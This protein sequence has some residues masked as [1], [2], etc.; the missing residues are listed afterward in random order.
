MSRRLRRLPTKHE[1]GVWRGYI[2][3]AEAVR[4]KLAD[5]LQ[6]DFG[7]SSG[8]Y[9]VLLTLSEAPGNRLRSTELAA[10]MGWEKS[11][12][13]HHLSRMERRNLVS[14]QECAD[15]NRGAWIVHTREGEQAFQNS[16]V[17]HLMAIREYF[18]E[19]LSPDEIDQMDA[20]TRKLR[21]KLNDANGG[22]KNRSLDAP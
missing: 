10:K 13:S 20:L 17:P 1:L 15:D 21:T 2:E 4:S 22:W 3:T 7:L 9:Q 6:V 11:R 5:Q 12:L 14:R 8:D 16:T 19:A 18:V